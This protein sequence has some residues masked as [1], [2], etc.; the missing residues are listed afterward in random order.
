MGFASDARKGLLFSASV[1]QKLAF[2][3]ENGDDRK[4]LSDA[5]VVQVRGERAIFHLLPEMGIDFEACRA[6]IVTQKLLFHF[7]SH[8]MSLHVGLCG[9]FSLAL[10]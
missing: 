9:L 8:R 4:F 2:R 10:A 1:A 5:P 7:L 6:S 3:F